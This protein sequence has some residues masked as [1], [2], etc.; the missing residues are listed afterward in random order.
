MK[1]GPTFAAELEVAG[2]KQPQMSWSSNGDI[3]YGETMTDADKIVVMDVLRQHDETKVP[4]VVVPAKTGAEAALRGRIAK[5]STVDDLKVL[6]A[7]IVSR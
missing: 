7:E 5:A 2:L 6:L 4:P 1:I 3:S